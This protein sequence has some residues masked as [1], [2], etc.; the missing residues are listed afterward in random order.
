MP[1]NSSAQTSKSSN[2]CS[3]AI[4]IAEGALAN[5]KAAE[6]VATKANEKRDDA[7]N[8]LNT[9]TGQRDLA[10]TERDTLAGRLMATVDERNRIDDAFARAISESADLKAQRKIDRL[11]W[12][13]IGGLGTA[14]IGVV[15]ILVIK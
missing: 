12:I 4:R 7:I 2:A 3:E 1:T 6:L 8:L 13:S 14:L 5:A 10:R 11:V 9:A 15:A